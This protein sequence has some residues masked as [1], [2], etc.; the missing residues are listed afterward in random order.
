TP[1]EI[2]PWSERHDRDPEIGRRADAL[3]SESARRDPDDAA[4][5]AIEHQRAA[6]DGGIAGKLTRPERVAEHHDRA[7][8]LAAG[9]RAVFVRGE[10]PARG[11]LETEHLEMIA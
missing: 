11:R 4:H 5:A 10:K 6:D 8:R 3:A 1:F 9:G 7:H 2:R